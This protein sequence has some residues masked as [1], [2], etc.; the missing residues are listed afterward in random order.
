MN[1]LTNYY[2]NLSEQLTA[3]YV[4][5]QRFLAEDMD[6]QDVVSRPTDMLSKVGQVPP[7]PGPNYD[8]SKVQTPKKPGGQ[9]PDK[10]KHPS[11]GRG[12]GLSK[13]WEDPF[14]K[15]PN[16]KEWKEWAR[17][18]GNWHVLNPYNYDTPE[19]F[20]WEWEYYQ[21]PPGP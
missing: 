6:G 19:F 12:D 7:G 5:L 13:G 14:K 18:P 16:S 11:G 9:S 20:Q 17:K 15:G 3:R 21:Q 2:K 4:Q 8:P 10:P 1:H